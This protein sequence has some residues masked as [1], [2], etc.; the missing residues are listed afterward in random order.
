MNIGEEWPWS[1]N[2]AAHR[3]ELLQEGRLAA[4]RQSFETSL[5]QFDA[6]MKLS[7]G[8]GHESCVGAQVMTEALE[9]CRVTAGRG[10]QLPRPV[11]NA[12]N[13]VAALAAS[14]SRSGSTRLW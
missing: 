3:L 7:T 13:A 8:P 10:M 5:E 6:L 4:N 9:V 2:G 14:S 12:S 1:F 11:A